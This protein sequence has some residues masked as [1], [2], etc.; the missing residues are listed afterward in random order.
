MALQPDNYINFWNVPSLLLQ[1]FSAPEFEATVI[2]SLDSMRNGDRTGL[3]IM[4]SDYSYISITKTN[5]LNISQTVCISADK[6]SNEKELD[7]ILIDSTSLYLRVNVAKEAI[8][9]FSYSIDG[10]KFIAV[11]NSFKAEPGR[12]IGAKV[13]IFN[14][15]ESNNKT[16]G[17]VDI[18]WFRIG[19]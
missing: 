14:I 19:Q 15:N 16:K 11:G 1:K 17:Y 7:K 10:E 18:D 4:G 5:S 3:I 13:G 9:N 12:W 8:C 6:N 2:I